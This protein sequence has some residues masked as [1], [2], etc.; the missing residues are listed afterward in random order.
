[1]F[2]SLKKQLNDRENGYI[3]SK[4]QGREKKQKSSF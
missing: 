1:M 3:L 4:S 2:G